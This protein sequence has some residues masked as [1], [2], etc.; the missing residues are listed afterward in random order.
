MGDASASSFSGLRHYEKKGAMTL[1]NRRGEK[2]RK[3]D[4][5]LF[6]LDGTLIDTSQGIFHSVRYAEKK[7][8]LPPA[9]AEALRFF[10]GPPPTAMY[11]KIYGLDDAAAQKA[12]SYH[13]EYGKAK[14]VYEAVPY[15][16]IELL[17]KGLREKGYR[18]AVATLKRQDI[19]EEILELCGLERYFHE[20]AG[21]D[22]GETYTKARII[23]RIIGQ[24][25]EKTSSLIVGDTV[26]DE[27]GAKEAGIAFL[28]VSY[29]FG[30]REGEGLCACPLDIWKYIE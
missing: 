19:A 28:G 7:M 10:L 23:E 12:T 11:K 18:L 21:M 29:G 5:I 16:G 27:A 1:A 13:R 9:D 26:Y 30:F 22:E 4:L 2:M 6:D 8:G 25:G 17:L 20:I 3:Y 14:A 24:L 15:A